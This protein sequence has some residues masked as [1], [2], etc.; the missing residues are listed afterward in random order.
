MQ[1]HLASMRRR[2]DDGALLFGGPYRSGFG[3]MALLEADSAAD[4]AAIMD[5]DPAV[6]AG[7]LAYNIADVRPYFDAIAGRAW[8]PAATA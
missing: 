4:A 8:S 2:Y 3:G 6:M 1:A 5:A 7:I